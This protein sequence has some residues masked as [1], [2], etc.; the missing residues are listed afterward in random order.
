MTS[1]RQIRRLAVIL[2]FAGTV[3][4]A[5]PALSQILGGGLP[6]LPGGGLT[7]GLPRSLSS[8]PDLP[9]PHEAAITASSLTPVE[10]IA[11]ALSAAPLA[12]VRRLTA[13]RLLREHPEQL[14]A[15]DAGRPV[16][17]GE[18]L[19]VGLGAATVERLRQS[20]F[21]VRA[22][23]E[24]NALG[25]QAFVLRLP[26]GQ[27]AVEALHRLRA[28]DHS[29]EYDFNHLYQEGGAPGASSPAQ[30]HILL[31]RDGQ[32]LRIGLIDGSVAQSG[33]TLTHARLVQRAFGPGGA[34][35]TAHATAVASLIVGDA[36][37]FRGA[38]PGA[39]LYVADVYGPSPA[40]GSATA[41]ARGLAW[42][43]SKTPVISISLVGPPNL[44]LR[45]TVEALIARGHLIVAAV[46]NDG[47]A[48]APL[49][50]AAYPGVVAVT[51]VDAHLHVLPEASRGAHVDFAAPGAD[52][53]AAGSNGGFV[54]V[55][56]TSFAA[57]IVAGLLARAISSSS[58]SQAVDA[59]GRVAIDL[60]VAGT[61]PV[62]GRGLVGAEVRSDPTAVGVSSRSVQENLHAPG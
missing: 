15:D 7:G 49:Y 1:K 59:L 21:T 58:P 19:G 46:G 57:P 4:L 60:G 2:A 23:D 18:V 11:R 39:T 14:E 6:G 5:P 17:R 9:I 56:G 10:R 13:E 12:E 52:M 27:S 47:P 55:R 32:G 8:P 22:Q 50:P 24:L 61:D 42:L 45:A 3:G 30:T 31:P 20:G 25:L 51:A 34:R 36:A 33:P 53:A 38:A 35:Q 26:R 54:S 40:G 62:Y 37:P 28:T 41:V 44:L 43:D 16:V 48:A 29:G